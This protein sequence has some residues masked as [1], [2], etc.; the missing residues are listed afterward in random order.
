MKR[1][2]IVTFEFDTEDYNF[3]DRDKNSLQF[4]GELVTAM[5]EGQADWPWV[6]KPEN[7]ADVKVI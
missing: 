1:K 2:V 6:V 3:F 5:F 7:G 4:A